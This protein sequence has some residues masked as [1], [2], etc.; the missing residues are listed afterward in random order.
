MMLTI[1][2]I[3]L[4]FDTIDVVIE[5][6]EGKVETYPSLQYFDGFP[7]VTLFIFIGQ[8]HSKYIQIL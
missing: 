8:R 1:G 4:C 6:I 5:F 3:F 2:A 7:E